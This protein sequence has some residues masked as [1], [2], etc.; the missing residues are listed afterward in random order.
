MSEE[1]RYVRYASDGYYAEEFD[2]Q[3]EPGRFTLSLSLRRQGERVW[4]VD[5]YTYD[6]PTRAQMA[7]RRRLFWIWKAICHY[8]N[9]G[10]ELSRWLPLLSE[11]SAT[12]VGLDA[13]AAEPE[14]LMIFGQ[15]RPLQLPPGYYL[16]DTD[17]QCRSDDDDAILTEHIY[18]NPPLAQALRW[19]EG[20]HA[21]IIPLSHLTEWCGEF[22][23]G[24][25]DEPI[26]DGGSGSSAAP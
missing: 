23:G 13:G 5:L 12:R 25:A 26:F 4:T 1:T 24:T 19:V 21:E 11:L 14:V 18:V 8:L 16:F 15:L 9:A 17:Q 7:D 6:N 10:G 20:V 22:S 2:S 3:L